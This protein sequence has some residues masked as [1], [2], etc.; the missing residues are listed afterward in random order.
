MS[1]ILSERWEL[2]SGVTKIPRN[3]A[4]SAIESGLDFVQIPY[5]TNRRRTMVKR[6][7]PSS[8]SSPTQSR[9]C[10]RPF[11]HGNPGRPPGSKNKVTRFLE[12]LVE[13]EGE[14]L[15]R[16][17]IDLA[18]TGNLRSLLYCMDRLL[19][20]RRSQPINLELPKIDRV[21]DV[22]PAIATVS[23]AVSNGIVTPE[24]ASRIVGVL[25]SYAN[26]I[27]ASE[28]AVRLEKVE[29][30]LKMQGKM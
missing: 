29:S 20:Q 19:P 14:T 5:R 21:Q 12:E 24:E 16:K 26:A 10:G 9:G 25:D 22:A 23:H 15:T 11:E 1:R 30:V 2:E 3:R 6:I 8:E 18:K 27:I 28:L 13:N 7:T 4:S 17:L